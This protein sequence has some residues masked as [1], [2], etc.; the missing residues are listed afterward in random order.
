MYNNY[1]HDNETKNHGSVVQDIDAAISRSLA[2]DGESVGI[3]YSEARAET[4]REWC[5]WESD[6]TYAFRGDTERNGRT[7]TWRIH[8][9][10]GK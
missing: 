7:E 9:V 8:L 6:E 4:L 2:A 3:E 10:E 5:E 1:P